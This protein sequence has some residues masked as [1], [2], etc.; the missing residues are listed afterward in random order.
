MKPASR[1]L[2]IVRRMHST[3][4]GPAG[5][6]MTRPTSTPFQQKRQHPRTRPGEPAAS[7]RKWPD[8]AQ[9]KCSAA[10]RRYEGRNRRRCP[11]RKRAILATHCPGEDD[12]DDRRRRSGDAYRFEFGALDGG[13]LP[14]AAWRGHPV[15]V[16]NTASFCGYTPQYR[17]LEAL[18]RRY[19]ERGLI[20]LGVPSNDFGQQ[21]PGSAAEIKE[22]CETNYQVD[23]PLTEKYRVIGGGAH[24][25]YR[26]VADTA[27]RGRRAALEFPQIPDRTG[28]PARRRLAVAGRPAR[29]A[30]SPARSRPCCRS[31]KPG[32]SA[33]PDGRHRL[34]RIGGFRRFCR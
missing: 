3:P 25:F 21:E 14:L 4:T 2:K 11:A 34:S 18:W 12:D 17:D 29:P 31:R 19:R 7:L 27:R 16:V 13:K 15:L 33:G 5:T 32:R 20:V 22:F 23:F 10:P 30:R 28:R 9:P 8:R 1:P 6:A 26:W 24:P